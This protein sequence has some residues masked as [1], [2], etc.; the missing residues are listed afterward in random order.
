MRKIYIYDI[1]LYLNL[2]LVIFKD[3]YTNQL[4][5][6]E[7]SQRRDDRVALLKFIKEAEEMIGFNNLAFDYPLLHHFIL[8]FKK[9]LTG[10][11]LVTELFNKGQQL[12]NSN[13]RWANIIRKPFVNQTDLFLINHYDNFAKSTNLKVLEFN[14]E[15][16]TI[17]ELPFRFDSILAP[18]EIDI[19]IEY[20]KNDINATHKFFT[21]NVGAIEFRKR[22]SKTYNHDFTNY[23]DVKIG[24]QILLKEVSN[25][26]NLQT[27]D[28][29]KMRTKREKML[30]ADIIF[31]YVK[32]KTPEFK[33]LLNWWKERTIT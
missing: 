27:W 17:Q 33:T 13:N 18:E 23:N 2:F 21:H 32:F 15:M 20:C 11:Q 25:G 4:Y 9:R 28:V 19:V 16:P 24:E 14:M 12:I 6:F 8:L 1:E 22:M 29:K 3:I 31:D 30:M 5:I 10:K 7:I 26:M